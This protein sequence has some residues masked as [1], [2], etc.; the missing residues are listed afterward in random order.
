MSIIESA[1]AATSSIDFELP[2]E[3]AP[4]LFRRPRELAVDDSSC[5]RDVGP[6]LFRLVLPDIEVGAS[7]LGASCAIEG[8]TLLRR[9]E[10]VES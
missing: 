7:A 8:P 6:T 9:V 3:L 4:K 10:A 5:G 2:I 1:G